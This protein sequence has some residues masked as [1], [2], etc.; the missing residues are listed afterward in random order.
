MN[1]ELSPER[2]RRGSRSQVVVV[3]VG[4]GG[5]VL[6]G[7]EQHPMVLST[8]ELYLTMGCNGL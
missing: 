7:G 4:G 2:Y 3:V 6:G 8:G 1:A 5:G